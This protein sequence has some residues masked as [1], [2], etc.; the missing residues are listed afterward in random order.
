MIA[1]LVFGFIVLS[2]ICL[3][4][5]IEGRKSPK[6]L[7]WFI[8]ALLLLVTSTYVTY[9]SILGFPK[10]DIPKKGLYLK[11]YIDEPRWIYLWVLGEDNIPMSYQ[12]IYSKATHES[13]EGVK[14]KAEDV[15]FMVLSEDALEGG[16]Q[17]L[18][19]DEGGER[20]GGYTIGGDVSFYEWDFTENMPQKNQE[21][22]R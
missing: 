8:P 2:A 5:L 3:W 20:G 6:F 14:G 4:L 7:I 16:G 18:V 19:G 9:T 11:H 1:I 15:K 17:E 22:S 12:L 13:L 21:V 10:V